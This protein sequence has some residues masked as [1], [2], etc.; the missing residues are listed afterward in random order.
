M[1]GSFNSGGPSRVAGIG[2]TGATFGTVTMGGVNCVR[3]KGGSAPRE[4]G[5]GER[6]PPPPPPRVLSAFPWSWGSVSTSGVRSNIFLGRGVGLIRLPKREGQHQRREHKEVNEQRIRP[7]KGVGQ[8]I[9]PNVRDASSMRGEACRSSL[10]R[11]QQGLD[12]RRQFAIPRPLVR[13]R[14]PRLRLVVTA[15]GRSPLAKQVAGLPEQ[16]H[17]QGGQVEQGQ[18]KRERSARL[19]IRDGGRLRTHLR[20]WIVT[21]QPPPCGPAIHA[22][23]VD[24]S[25]AFPALDVRVACEVVFSETHP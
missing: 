24:F 20:R 12:L 9:L 21:Q 7:R 5:S 16:R 19:R 6:S 2:K 3:A 4:A 8:I 22:A 11:R 25:V 13:E 14:Q 1:A 23:R 10:R 15:R 18:F 17:R